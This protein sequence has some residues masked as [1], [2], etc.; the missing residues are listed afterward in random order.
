MSLWRWYWQTIF[1]RTLPSHSLPLSV[2][3]KSTHARRFTEN[4][5]PPSV[6]SFISITFWKTFR[7]VL[8]IGKTL[9]CMLVY[10]KHSL[11]KP[12]LLLNVSYTNI[13]GLFRLNGIWDKKRFLV[14]KEDKLIGHI[15]LW[16]DVMNQGCVML[17]FY[18]IEP[19]NILVDL[20]DV[21]VW[22]KYF[23]K[24]IVHYRSRY[25]GIS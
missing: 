15:S 7:V 6:N 11:L 24:H 10:Y 3:T 16:N 14:L 25:F 21:P 5:T 2:H 23:K 8:H 18:N 13:C 17:W 1:H 19:T 12:F 22:I 9:Y 4:R 20:F